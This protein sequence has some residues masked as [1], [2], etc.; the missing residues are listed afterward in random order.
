MPKNTNILLIRHAEKPSEKG[1]TSLSPA[2]QARAWA[3]VAYFQNLV[4]DA[5][6]IKLHHLFATAQSSQSNRPYLTIQPLSEQLG[7]TINNYYENSGEDI[8]AL[9]KYV[10]ADEQ[11]NNTNILVCWHH[12]ELLHL[13]KVLGAQ[14]HTLPNDWPEDAFGWLVQ[15]SFDEHGELAQPLLIKQKLMYTDADNHS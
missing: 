15:L 8:E 2:G 3:Y 13:V 9:A 4:I 12:Q 5:Q 11:F 7:L 10:L 1:N 14:L 6:P